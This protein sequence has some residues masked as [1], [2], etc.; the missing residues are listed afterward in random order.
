MSVTLVLGQMLWADTRQSPQAGWGVAVEGG[1][2]I[3]SI[4]EIPHP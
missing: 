2:V 3:V 1:R 4:K